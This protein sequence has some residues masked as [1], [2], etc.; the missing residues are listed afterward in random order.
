MLSSQEKLRIANSGGFFK[1]TGSNS[2]VGSAIRKG[3][4]MGKV[5]SDLNG[6]CRRLKV[7]FDDGSH[8]EIVLNNLGPD[9]EEC[10]QYEWLSKEKWYRF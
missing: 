6:M 7:E 5:V 8:D 2:W 10:H 9:P 4:K 1:E 3:N